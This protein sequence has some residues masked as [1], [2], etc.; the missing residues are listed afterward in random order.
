MRLKSLVCRL[1][2]LS[3]S[4]LVL[5]ACGGG[6]GSSSAAV[7]PPAA[8]GGTPPA[9]AGTPAADSQR[10]Q[11]SD[12]TPEDQASG[13][14]TTAKV[15]VIFDEALDA[16][17]IDNTSVTVTEQAVAVPGSVTYDASNTSLVFTPDQA[18]AAET[19]YGVT[20]ASTVMDAAGN[21][22][23]GDDWFFTTGGP[24][25]LGPTSQI[26][27]D[28]CMSDGDKQMLTLVNQA[29]EAGATCGSDDLPAQPAL[30][31]SCLLDD[32][33]SGHSMAM[34]TNDFHAHTSPVDGTDAGDRV[35]AT[36]YT[37]RS[38][39]ENIGAGY[40][41]ENLVM[42]GWLASAG[43]C[44]NLLSSAFTEMGAGFAEDAGSTYGIYWTQNFADPR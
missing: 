35:R 29:R 22:F 7:A 10:P 13:V 41:D 30:G 31:W 4:T 1:L 24:F 40:A 16:G 32:A 3:G 27:I 36:G 11:V 21:L 8:S 14:S 20:I 26:T 19:V 15:V 28:Q 17:S 5:G 2:L 23:L 44:S 6:G 42:Q 38:W 33:A 9:A 37:P 39:G 18:L 25:N 12:R 34:A 43:H